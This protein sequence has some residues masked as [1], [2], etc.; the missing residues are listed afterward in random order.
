MWPGTF[1]HHLN[2]VSPGLPGQLAQRFQFGELRRVAGIGHAA[3]PQSVAQREADIVLLENLADLIKMF[4]QEILLVVLD[5]PFGQDR[6]AAAHD[7]GDALGSKRNVLHQH[8]GVNGHV[9][10]ALLGLLLDHFQHHVDVQ[11]FYAAHS[12]ERFVDRHGA[13]RNRRRIND[14]FPDARDIATGG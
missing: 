10:H 11:I 4:V 8:A 7:A 13:H 5:H 14:G 12:A 3:R 2:I 6:S 1:D 9:I